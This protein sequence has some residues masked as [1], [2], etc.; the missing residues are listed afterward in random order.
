METDHDDNTSNYGNLSPQLAR[1]SQMSRDDRVPESASQNGEI[2]DE[3]PESPPRGRARPAPQDLLCDPEEPEVPSARQ[4]DWMTA[5][6]LK[7]PNQCMPTDRF[8]PELLTLPD[9][10]QGTMDAYG[11]C[12]A[13]VTDDSLM[14]SETDGASWVFCQG[15]VA[16]IPY[17]IQQMLYFFHILQ[18][19]LQVKPALF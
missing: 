7:H 4:K 5:D 6:T 17:D 8:H 3:S 12:W 16:E 14:V 19:S 9:H 10:L 18:T 15:C 13:P 11:K 2:P 1:C